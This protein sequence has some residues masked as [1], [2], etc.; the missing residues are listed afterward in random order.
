V[1][2]PEGG[3]AVSSWHSA[4]L[5]TYLGGWPQVALSDG[6][7]PGPTPPL[8]DRLRPSSAVDNFHACGKVQYSGG[9]AAPGEH[10]QHWE[11]GES[12]SST[13]ATKLI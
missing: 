7:D 9:M 2:G 3:E 12:Y 11:H 5:S 4:F 6:G 10:P 1:L 13:G 8:P